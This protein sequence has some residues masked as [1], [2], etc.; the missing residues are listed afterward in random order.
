MRVLK[1]PAILLLFLTCVSSFTTPR[2]NSRVGSVST[3]KISL[4]ERTSLFSADNQVEESE[5]VEKSPIE[6]P[7]PVAVEPEESPYPINLPSPIL[8]SV[9]MVLAI[10]GT[11]KH[12]LSAP[13]PIG[14]DLYS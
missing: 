5:S 6:P 2:Y 11:G 13:S 14:E 7:A 3:I 12:K 4:R 8:L 1:V 10:A 9:S